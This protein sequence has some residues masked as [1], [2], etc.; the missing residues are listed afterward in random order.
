M[1]I[2]RETQRLSVENKRLKNALYDLLCWVDPNPEGP[3]W[4]TPEARARNREMCESAVAAAYSCL[5]ENYDRFGV[6]VSA[7]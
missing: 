1:S 2:S 4:A 7:N 3:S 5:P 6:E